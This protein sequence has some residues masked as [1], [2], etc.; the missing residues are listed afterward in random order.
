[1]SS[2]TAEVKKIGIPE[3]LRDPTSQKVYQRGEPR[4]ISSL[5]VLKN[6]LNFTYQKG[7]QI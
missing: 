1:M 5:L 2:K 7:A 3:F 6:S 4:R